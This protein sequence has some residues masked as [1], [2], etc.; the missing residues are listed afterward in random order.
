[1][2]KVP[3]AKSRGFELETFWAEIHERSTPWADQTP[4]LVIWVFRMLQNV[5]SSD[6][7]SWRGQGCRRSVFFSIKGC[8]A[9]FGQAAAPSYAACGK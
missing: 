6:H 2:R 7:W 5:R 8:L 3:D 1:M 9:S 4:M